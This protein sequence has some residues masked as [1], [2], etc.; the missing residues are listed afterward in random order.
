MGLPRSDIRRIFAFAMVGGLGIGVLVYG[1][2]RLVEGGPATNLGRSALF[3][4]L[5]GLLVG[6]ALVAAIKFALRQA[7][8]DL[9]TYAVALTDATLPAPPPL[10]GDDVVAMRETLGAALASLPRPG[11]LPQLAHDLGAALDPAGALE[12]AADQITQHIPIRGALL[13]TVDAERQALV[14]VATWGMARLDRAVALDLD[15]SA[16]GR[17]LREQRE[18][19]YSGLQVRELLPLQLGPEA[20]TLF[21][22][23]QHV[24]GQPFGT[25]CLL[26]PGSDVRLS[27]EQRAFA[28]GVGDL[29]TLAVQ[30]SLHRRL[31]T[32]E[33]ERLF[34]FEEI[35]G[36]LAGSERLE[37]ALEQVLRVAARVTDSA[38]G[39]LLLVEPDE[40]R[41]RYRVTLKE[42]DVLPLSVTA[43]P[44]LKH[45]LAGWAL[46]ERRADIV[47]DTERDSR[48][49]PIP[50]L[51][52]M[53]SV[54][55]IPLLYGERALGVLT[56]AD[57]APRHY[58][59]RS[60]ALCSALAAYAVTIL[61]R[62]QYEEMVAPGNAALVRR[63]FE[64][65]VSQLTM[66][67]LLGDVQA[68]RG[69]LEP[70]SRDLVVLCIGLR[71]LD[72]IPLA[73]AQ[74]LEQILTPTLTALAAIGHEHH[75][76]ISAHDDGTVL[77]VFGYPAAASDARIRALR[78]AQA[79]QAAARR[80]RGRWRAQLG[81]DLAL[82]AGLASGD[83]VTGMVG[84]SRLSAVALIGGAVAEAARLQRLARHDEVLVTDTLASSF[85]AEGIFPL[86]RLAPLAAGE[87]DAP[88][89]V[90]RLASGRG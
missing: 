60:L 84:D 21:C 9:H 49:L 36:L 23:P 26:A 56:L 74:L 45:G 46:R 40:S 17:A 42:G 5:A 73:P 18:T 76:F 13:L 59:R 32:R 22:L 81:H 11:V 88:R 43:A 61:A 8:Y 66:S 44:I 71:G 86:E 82:S 7:A 47:D 6:L 33:S 62:M 12:L 83:L 19:D 65:R 77:M 58:S 87:G 28:R 29:L 67:D 72:R 57:S 20:L 51:D 34:A 38:H 48:W 64:G 63:L 80:L 70:Q 31:F 39:S 50:G 53:R 3:A 75:A 1:F 52:A 90:Y 24:R 54:L 69:A 85:G 15:D 14:P 89:S 55:V 10:G 2:V 35:G 25:L 4:L 78:A 41:V 16:I 27:P 79:V 68:L 30:S 37:R